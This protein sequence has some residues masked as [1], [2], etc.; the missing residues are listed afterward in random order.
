MAKLPARLLLLQLPLLHGAMTGTSW[1]LGAA[2]Q[3]LQGTAAWLARTASAGG[4]T[5]AVS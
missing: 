3:V 4:A 1:A 2:S 5:V